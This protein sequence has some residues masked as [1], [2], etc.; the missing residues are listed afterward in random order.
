MPQSDSYMQ[1]KRFDS[2]KNRSLRAHNAAD[3]Y[4]LEKY[5]SFEEKPDH[6]GIYFDRFGFLTAHVHAD[7]PICVLTQKSQEKAILANCAANKLTEPEF[8]DPLSPLLKP[9]DFALIQVPKSIAQLE[10]CLHHIAQNSS[11]HVTVILGFMTRHF[12]PSLLEICSKY[13]ESVEQSRAVKKARLITLTGKKE[14]TTKDLMDLV[15]F[16]GF[17]YKQYYGVFSAKHIDY[18]T[19]FFVEHLDLRPSDERILDIGSGNGIISK[20]IR[21]RMPDAELHLLEDSY[22]AYESGQLN[23][24]GIS[25]HHHYDNN[26]DSFEDKSFDLIVTNPPFHFEYE[27]NIET[28]IRLFKECVRC[29][30]PGGRLQIVANKHLNYLTHLKP[31]FRTVEVLNENEKFI[32]YHCSMYC[33]DR[34][35]V[36]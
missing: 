24:T 20:V 4:L 28:P 23:L 27:I 12:T 29:L 11:E 2:S 19:Q 5:N 15:E 34:E 16:D 22:L 32:I 3:E 18:A 7:Q 1:I 26:L 36:L 13:F 31:I 10:L 25:I 14:Q 17:K 9:V 30:K 21:T 33:S 35:S 6:L 8:S